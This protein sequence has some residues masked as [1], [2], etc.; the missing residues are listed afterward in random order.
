MLKKFEVTNFKN[1][2][3]T[4]SFDLSKTKSYEFNPKCVKSGIVNKSLVYGYNGVGKS[5]LG[6]AIF[7]LI[8]H[9][10]DRNNGAHCYENYLN[11]Y[12]RDGIAEF[13]YVFSFKQG[14]VVYEYG[15]S[16]LESLVY[17]RLTINGSD[18]ASIDR[19]QNS[20]AKINAAG[21]ES[22]KTDVGTS[23]I[24]I[25]SYIKKNSILEGTIDNECFFEFIDFINGMLFFRSL[26]KNDYI[27]LEQGG[28]SI[29]ADIVEQGHLEGFESFLNEAGVECKLGL[30]GEG[31]ANKIGF[32]FDGKLI[33]FFEIASQ[34]TKSLSLFYFWLQRLK[35]EGSP[36][37]FLFIDEFDAFYHHDLSALIVDMLRNVK[38]QVIITTH[39]TSVMTN[40]LLRPDCYFLMRSNGMH[41]LASSTSKE[42]REAHN[43]EKM[44][45]AGSF[46]G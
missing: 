4:L 20:V 37:T 1:F 40:D 11:A 9:L 29:G 36:V 33:P 46:S 25:V 45:K 38:A 10:T 27:G 23:S 19:R 13:K 31:D 8:S 5:N 14:E 35:G 32:D 18:F 44:Y 24:S 34:G 22:L 43:I 39:N 7:D 15:K 6:F 12:M 2:K 26:D 42:L 17:E 28:G 21:A 3:D 30:M 41:S 16:D